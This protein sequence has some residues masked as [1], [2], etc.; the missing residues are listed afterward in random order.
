[1]IELISSHHFRVSWFLILIIVLLAYLI[2]SIFFSVYDMAIDTL[3]LS[4]RKYI[5]ENYFN[6]HLAIYVYLIL[7]SF[8]VED[9]ERNDG[10]AERP[11]F[12]SQKLKQ[13]YHKE[14]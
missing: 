11:Y 14:E 7:F 8:A 4:Y 3:F 9:S 5:F 12:M 10:S 2:T 1:M 6:H 13:I